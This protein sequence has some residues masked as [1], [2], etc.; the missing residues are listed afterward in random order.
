MEEQVPDYPKKTFQDHPKYGTIE[1]WS[2][3]AGPNDWDEIDY[4]TGAYEMDINIHY[5]EHFMGKEHGDRLRDKMQNY[6]NNNSY[7]HNTAYHGYGQYDD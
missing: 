5:Q 4:V 6:L 1:H 3:H 7:D 2:D